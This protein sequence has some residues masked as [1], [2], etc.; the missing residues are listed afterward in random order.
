[1][2][3]SLRHKVQRQSVQFQQSQINSNILDPFVIRPSRVLTVACR[4]AHCRCANI[5]VFPHTTQHPTIHITVT[6]VNSY[7]QLT[8]ATVLIYR[9]AVKFLLAKASSKFSLSYK[10]QTINFAFL[11]TFL[12]R[13]LYSELYTVEL[14]S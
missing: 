3:Q 4:V 13:Q 11:S 14:P 2:I 1:M 8:S 7:L 5:Y 10:S 12:A 9:T 6:A